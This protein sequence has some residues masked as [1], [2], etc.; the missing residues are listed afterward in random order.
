MLDIKF[1]GDK[2]TNKLKGIQLGAIPEA[3]K[4]ITL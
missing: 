1:D 4:K 2:F 3:Q